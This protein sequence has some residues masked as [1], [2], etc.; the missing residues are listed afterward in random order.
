MERLRRI[1]NNGDSRAA[2]AFDLTIQALIVG[3]LVAFPFETMPQMPVEVHR[4]LHYFEVFT[5]AVFTVEYLLRILAAPN[6]LRFIFSFFGLIDLLAIL[7]FYLALGVDARSLRA[8]RL[9]R[10]IRTFKFVR[11]SQALRRF[12]RAVTL[13]REEIVL[14]L[15]VAMLML[16]FSAIGIYYFEH[17]A[18]PEAY[19]TIFDSLWWA[20]VTLTTVGYGD[21]Y[22]ITVGGRIFTFFVLIT[23]L[24]FVA[25]PTGLLAS[26]LSKARELE[27]Q[28]PPADE[29]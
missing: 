9:F 11:Y 23:G 16:Y 20:V 3:S 15:G 29:S 13:A 14:F 12:W 8:F 2:R 22:P 28:E 27:E 19:A 18:Q 10:L 6:R 26:A 4:W 7:P 17:E 24:G 25:I 1:L 21:I 5:V